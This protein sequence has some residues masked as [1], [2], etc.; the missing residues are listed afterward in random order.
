MSRRK[1]RRRR[2]L[3]MAWLDLVVLVLLVGSVV[4]P[5]SHAQDPQINTTSSS[6]FPYSFEDLPRCHQTSAEL[7]A[8]NRTTAVDP[9]ILYDTLEELSANATMSNVTTIITVVGVFSS[10]S[11]NSRDG[12]M[13]AVQALNADNDGRG[14]AIGYYKDHYVQFRFLAGVAGNRNQLGPD[15]YATAHQTML[16]ILLEDVKPNYIL[17]TRSFDAALERP[18]AGEY[19]TML[20]AQVGPQ[21]F[22]T[23]SSESNH[24]IFGAHI[25][26]EGYGIPAFQ[27][28]RFAV[29]TDRQQPIR[30]VYRDRSEF[31]YSTCRAVYDR[32][33]EEG[34][35]QQT[36][37]IEYNPNDDH[38]QDGIPNQD[39]ID[40]LQGVA[41]QA[42]SGNDDDNT[43]VAIWAC[44]MSDTEV[45]TVL[46]R[47]RHNGCRFNMLWLTV[48]SWAWA[49]RFPDMVPYIQ[50][51]GQ[52][53]KS[54]KYADEYFDSGQAM[55]DHMTR[56]FGY[57]PSYSALG[58]Y[59][60]IY[61]MY[62][63]VRKFFQGKDHPQVAQV[64]ASPAQYEELR[65]SMLDL[66][67]PHTLY[68]PTSFDEHRRNAGRGS[69]GM[70]WD[71]PEQT[72]TTTNK[73]ADKF[74]L[75]LVSPIDQATTAVRFPAPAARS[76]PPGSFVNASKIFNSTALLEDKCDACPVDTFQPD[77]EDDNHRNEYACRPCPEGS[78]TDGETG[79][80]ICVQLQDNLVSAGLHVFGYLVMV[81]VFC[82]AIGFA[83]WTIIHRED[84]VVRIGQVEFLLLICLGPIISSSSI[85]LLSVQA[86][87]LDDE[88]N[89][90]R[91]CKALP[92]LYT[93]GWMLQYGSLSAKSYRMYS[94][95]KAAETMQGGRTARKSSDVVSSGSAATPSFTIDVNEARL[96]TADDDRLL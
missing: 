35:T 10:D 78:G 47:W 63:N 13:V 4:T 69:A 36:E 61:L 96:A 23:S 71:V 70:Q 43:G 46:D 60:A 33:M 19:R 58:A 87:S 15:A 82:L 48:A 37:A 89:A 27:A 1:R 44:L 75:L 8:V 80:T 49:Q 9:C 57:V 68:G 73:T 88:S 25:P 26:S 39:D 3:V 22:Y 66:S 21:S 6:L 52:W 95:M 2:R 64:F 42:C 50:S 38:D 83:V 72:T 77:D 34:F 12:G 74:E 65:R 54:M 40:F 92:W 85:A 90:N 56:Q 93:T 59:H 45:N 14:A 24:H 17:G 62:Q 18:I 76:C 30:I 29:N 28:L 86:G 20:L 5:V 51:G 53:H 55:L 32:A 81:V 11:D 84:P 79:A 16:R 91:A 94:T 31:F 7:T 41:D 67:L